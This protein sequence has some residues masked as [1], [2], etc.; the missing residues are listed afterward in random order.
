MSRAAV[1]RP[2]ADRS[3][4]RGR[5]RPPQKATPVILAPGLTIE[6]AL[7]QLIGVSL[8][9]FRANLDGVQRSADP[10]YVHQ[11]RV[12]VRR[13]RCAAHLFPR[14]MMYG[15]PR[16]LN[17]SLKELSALLGAVRDP[18]VFLERIESMPD[19]L[20]PK[21]VA[22]VRGLLA[23]RVRAAREALRLYL[24]SAAHERF[25]ARLALWTAAPPGGDQDDGALVDVARR[26]LSSWHRRIRRAAG[27]VQ[28]FGDAEL[29]R[30]RIRIKRSRYAAEFFRGL[31]NEKAG[32]SYV[33]ALGMAQDRLGSLTDIKTGQA[34]LRELGLDDHVS[35]V[36][37]ANLV[38]GARV[39]DGELA[40]L[41]K[42]CCQAGGY[43]KRKKARK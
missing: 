5:L 12:A 7:R 25:A 40:S 26:R 20:E 30:L 15:R 2:E 24:G 37:H 14:D 8:G 38:D 31:F 13:M 18:E 4:A 32:R 34:L 42:A 16:R 6:A 3:A 21:E 35:S 11:L 36:L 19:V 1:A 43:W 41:L 23:T 33:A 39:S 28:D 29:H 27:H 10:E 17:A 9:H 22:R